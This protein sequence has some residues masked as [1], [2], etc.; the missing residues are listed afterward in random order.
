MGMVTM[1]IKKDTKFVISQAVNLTAPTIAILITIAFGA[2]VAGTTIVNNINSQY[3][4]NGEKLS[5]H[6]VAQYLFD[7]SELQTSYSELET[8][9]NNV[10]N[11]KN[12]IF[13]V[14]SQLQSDYAD[15]ELQNNQI[16]TEKDS[17][18]EE[19]NQ[20]NNEVNAT[21]DVSFSSPEITVFGE[22]KS[23]TFKEY[24]A[25]IDGHLYIRNDFLNSILPEKMSVSSNELIYGE[26]YSPKLNVVTSAYMHDSFGLDIYNNFGS[27][28]MSGKEYNNGF[29]NNTSHETAVC[30]ECDEKYSKIQFTLGHIDNSGSGSKYIEIDY[31]DSDGEYKLAYSKDLASDMPVEDVIVDIYNTRTIKIKFNTSSN[32]SSVKFGMADVYLIE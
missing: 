29:V 24:I 14:Y 18:Q 17:I 11:E 5:K 4:Y 15:L 27:F 25:D 22:E 6:E 21:P 31:M 9:L 23:T 19:V 30:I 3:V 32:Y 13:E 12:T 10:I 26:G 2:G 20:L 8:Q 28:I 16:K 1:V 7:Y